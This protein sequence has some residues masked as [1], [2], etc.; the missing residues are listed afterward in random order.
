[1]GDI[2]L[3]PEGQ[4]TAESQAAL[5]NK[6]IDWLS[7][8]NQIAETDGAGD[9][10]HRFKEAFTRIKRQIWYDNDTKIFDKNELRVFG[11][12]VMAVV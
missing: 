12:A 9:I 6:G 11:A 3:T 4:L 10:I 1:M 2:R 5:A 7:Q 8:Q